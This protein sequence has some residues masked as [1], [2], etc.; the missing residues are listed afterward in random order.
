MIKLNSQHRLLAMVCLLLSACAT[1][2]PIIPAP[3]NLPGRVAEQSV[4]QHENEQA[5]ELATRITKTPE[6][7]ESSRT[8]AGVATGKPAPVATNETADITLSFEQIPLISFIKVVFAEILKKNV[9]IDPQVTARKDLLTLRTGA[10]QT[11]TQ[12]EST[13]KVL[14]KSYGIAV[15]EIGNMVR[16]VPDNAAL[17]YLPEI[18]QGRALPDTPLPLRP[19]FQLVSLNVVRVAEVSS[20]IKTMFGDKVKIQDDIGRNTLVLNGQSDNVTAAMEAIQ[21]LDQPAMKGRRSARVNPAFWSADDLAKKL[22]DIL[23]AEGYNAGSNAPFTWTIT[24]LPVPQANA[25]VIFTGDTAVLEH[26][27]QW[28]QELDKPNEKTGGSNL[29]SY[30]AQYTDA[31]ELAKTLQQLIG[32]MVAPVGGTGRAAASAAQAKVVVDQA[33]NTLLI[34]GGQDAKQILSVLQLIDKPSKEALIEVTVAELTLDDNSQL[35]IEW[36]IQQ[37]Q[38]NGASVVAGT[39]GGLALGTSGFNYSRINSAGDVKILLNALASTNRATILSSPRIVARNG[40]AAT[41]QVGQEVPIITSQQVTTTGSGTATTSTNVPQS[42]QYRNT[43]VILRV[44]PIIH[45]GEMIDLEISQE[46]SAAQATNTGVSTSP[47]FS[48]RKVQT[49]LTLKNGVTVLLGGLISS[50]QSTGNAGVPLL[51]DIPGVGMLFKTNTDKNARTELIVL[52]TPYI[53]NDSNDAFEMT[54]AFRNQLGEWAKSPSASVH[55]G[56]QTA[57]SPIDATK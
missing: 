2:Q 19:V 11:R 25:V 27:I 53:I 18:R 13:A 56:V 51:K 32:G 52:I 10:A 21:L 26:V 44:K 39:A 33:S 20:W 8:Q 29:M 3:L 14:L 28:A 22:I 38:I 15:V 5:R 24:L 49:N 43:G 48:T 46:V 17:G 45:S 57:P 36:L 6:L 4:L 12:V 55:N 9:N 1:E 41:I 50:N 7:P 35:G 30:Q 42:V 40:Q 47:T 23:Q 34:Q 16:I 31:T 54:R 37:T